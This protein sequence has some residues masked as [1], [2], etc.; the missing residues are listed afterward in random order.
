MT[1][2]QYIF[3]TQFTIDVQTVRVFKASDVSYNFSN[4]LI[5][6]FIITQERFV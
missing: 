4:L 1:I 3:N 2:I 5:N 6:K